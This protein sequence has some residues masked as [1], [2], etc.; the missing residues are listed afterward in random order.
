VRNTKDKREGT[1]AETQLRLRSGV[2]LE[3]LTVPQPVK[4]FQHFMEPESSLPSNISDY[5]NYIHDIYS[6]HIFTVLLLHGSAYPQ[7]NLRGELT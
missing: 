5:T 7:I 1:K 4:K 3:K 6:L 2:P